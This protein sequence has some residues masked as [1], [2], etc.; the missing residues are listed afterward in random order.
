MNDVLHVLAA[1]WIVTKILI[2]WVILK[3]VVPVLRALALKTER[4]HVNGQHL[5]DVRMK[6]KGLPE[7]VAQWLRSMMKSK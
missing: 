3:N 1:A 4:D 6:T 2:S 7:L 5:A